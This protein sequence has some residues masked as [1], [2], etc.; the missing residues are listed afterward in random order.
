MKSMQSETWALLVG[1]TVVGLVGCSSDGGVSTHGETSDAEQ[2]ALYKAPIDTKH[3]FAVGVCTGPLNT[4]P[5]YGEIGACSHKGTVARCTGSLIAPNLVLTAR[6]CVNEMVG[7]SS[8]D[9]QCGE[10]T[11]GPK[12]PFAGGVRV[13]TSHTVMSDHP[14]WIDV[15]RVLVSPFGN[16]FCNDDVALL[17]LKENVT[18]VTPAWVDLD[19]DIHVNPP[20]DGKFAIVGRGII[21]HTDD[22]NLERRYLTDIPFLCAD[23]CDLPWNEGKFVFHQAKG[24]FAFGQSIDSG[25]SG[26]GILLNETFHDAQPTIVGVE[27][28]GLEDPLTIPSGGIAVGLHHHRGWLTAGAYTAAK[29]GGYPVPAWAH[30]D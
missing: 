3:P 26:A 11:F 24:Q 17:I 20:S 30:G 9:Y 27:S 2:S 29:A 19:R 28:S 7:E 5:A 8:D 22:G 25:D 23:A 13:T 6:H 4:D 12:P 14:V 18:R 16:D 21:S 1:V 15:K 10:L